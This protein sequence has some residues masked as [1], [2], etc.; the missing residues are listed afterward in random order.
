[1]NTPNFMETLIGAAIALVVLML[2]ITPFYTPA[3]VADGVR[4]SGLKDVEITGW[5]PL[6]CSNGD[7]FCRHFEATR[8]GERV[9]GVVGCGFFKSCTIRW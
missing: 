8:D 2:L 9:A 1:M 6:Q 3:F 7:A 5:A 4:A